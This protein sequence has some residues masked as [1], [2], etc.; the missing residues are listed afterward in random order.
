MAQ[1]PVSV[2]FGLLSVL[3]QRA[4]SAED[5][6]LID[7]LPDS[8]TGKSCQVQ[9]CCKRLHI[10]RANVVPL[11]PPPRENAADAAQGDFLLHLSAYG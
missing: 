10:S 8:R 1:V 5:T 9:R 6:Q 7:I 11:T 3:R 4:A 2:Q